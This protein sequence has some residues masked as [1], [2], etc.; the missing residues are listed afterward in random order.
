MKKLN[1][2][3]NLR[4]PSEDYRPITLPYYETRASISFG[5]EVID[6]YCLTFFK[7]TKGYDVTLIQHATHGYGA[8]EINVARLLANDYPKIKKDIRP[9]H[10]LLKM[11]LAGLFEPI[12]GT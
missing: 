5:V 11:F 10:N 12:Q 9:S 6:T 1:I 8:F 3:L 7:Q 4:P 2:H